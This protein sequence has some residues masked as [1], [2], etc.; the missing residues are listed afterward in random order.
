MEW[1]HHIELYDETPIRQKPR[2]FPEPVT[3]E[4]ERQCE[5]LV[6][7]DILSY[8]KSP[9]SSPIV[10]V[11]KKDGSIRMCIDYR[12]LN[13][14]TKADRFP[15]PN[16]SDLVFGLHGMNCFSTLDLIKGYYQVSLHPDSQ[17]CTYS[18]LNTSTSL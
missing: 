7:L 8:S 3:R 17:E 15:I 5:E 18:V 10:P 16:M 2:R 12:E 14:V 9:W 4:L 11:R 6:A 1:K 13:K